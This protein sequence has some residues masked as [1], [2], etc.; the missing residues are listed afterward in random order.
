ML[1]SRDWL[2]EYVALP[3]HDE[4]VDRLTMSGLNHE[5]SEMVGDDQQI[6]LEVTSNRS[7]CLGHIGVAREI[8]VLF[9]TPLKLPAPQPA[10]AGADISEAFDVQ[11]DCPELCYRF[12]ARLIRGVK[13]GPSPDWLGERLQTVMGKILIVALVMGLDL[14]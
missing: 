4:L 6:D 11:I 9:E 3:N 8:S 5:G 12:T 7:D 14:L 1:V 10:T 13:V 2:K